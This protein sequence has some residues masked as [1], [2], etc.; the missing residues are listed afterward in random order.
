MTN[1]SGGFVEWLEGDIAYLSV[2]F[3]WLL[4][5][6]Y[7]RSKEL[8]K[9]GYK[10]IA[11]GP[12]VMY[13]FNYLKDIAEIK[14]NIPTLWRHNP[15]ATFTSRGCIRDCPFCIVTKIE[16]EYEELNDWPV[17]PIVCDNNFL[18]CS[19][20]HFNSVIDKLK[21]LQGIDFNQGLDARLMTQEKAN[22]LAELDLQFVRLSWDWIGIEKQY[23]KAFQ[24]IRN[25][26]IPAKKIRTYVLLGF[27]DTPE[28]ALYRLETVK[29][30][31]AWPYPMRYQ[32]LDVMKRNGY[33]SSNWTDRQLKDY[34]R[35][36][37]KLKYLASVPFEEYRYDY[38]YR[39]Q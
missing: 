13:N 12:A 18:A 14:D 9:L 28:D 11:G 27:N 33:V 19:S 34:V 7:K 3:S 29:K 20:K 24:M 25:A 35:Y 17:L 6:A 8:N 39:K 38:A 30:L 15:E 32:P 31:G 4:P 1:W 22:R 21:P 10:V 23:L 16:P 37:S 36:W 2:V 5:K 26:G